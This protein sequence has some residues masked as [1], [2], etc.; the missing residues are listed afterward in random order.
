MHQDQHA[1]ALV[2]PLL[3]QVLTE[4]QGLFAGTINQTSSTTKTPPPKKQR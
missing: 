2:V 1:V 3:F 4:D